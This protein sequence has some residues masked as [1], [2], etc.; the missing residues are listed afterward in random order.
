M[1]LKISFKRQRAVFKG[2]QLVLTCLVGLFCTEFTFAAGQPYVMSTSVRAP[3][4]LDDGSGYFNLLTTEIFRRLE[5]D[6]QLIQLPEQRALIIANNKTV[7]G[8]G[9]RTAA[10][11]QTF[12]NLTRVPVYILDFDFMAYSKNPA[13]SISGWE[14]LDPYS[15]DLINGWKIVERNTTS[16]KLVMKA[17]NYDQLFQLFEKGRIDIAIMGREMGGWQLRQLGFDLHA[18]EPSIITKPN[19]LYVHMDHANLVPQIARVLTEMR[20]DGRLYDPRQYIVGL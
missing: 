14:S 19:F 20:Q 10:I 9:P 4:Y 17:T 7:D 16:A 5:I 1:Q 6:Y 15:V 2:W 3:L 8:T 13:V 11:A 18:I 12:P